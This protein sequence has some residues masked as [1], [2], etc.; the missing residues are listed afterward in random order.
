MASH[1][2]KFSFIAFHFLLFTLLFSCFRL[3]QEGPSLPNESNHDSDDVI[4]IM[5]MVQ[6][7]KDAQKAVGSNSLVG[8]CGPLHLG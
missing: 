2:R 6:I 8:L 7:V 5:E 3:S 4:R 1:L